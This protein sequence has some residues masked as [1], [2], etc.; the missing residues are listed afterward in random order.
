[1]K[2]FFLASASLGL[3]ASFPSLRAAE[4]S[5]LPPPWQHQD[6]G[7]VTVAGA[8]SVTKG[9][10]SLSGTLDIWGQNDGC[11][12]AWQPLKGNGTIIARVLSVEP[13]QNH[14]KGGVAVRESLAADARH[15]TLVDTPTD[16]AQF[17]VREQPG[18]VTTS[19]KSGL[20]KAV[21]P[22]WVKLV[23]EGDTFTGYESTDGRVW[24]QIGSTTLKLPETVHLGLVAS[25]HQKDKLCAATFD[26]VAVTRV[27]K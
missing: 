15:V 12:F 5:A 19:K 18:G 14:A 8:A 1:M 23:R 4:S 16:G 9:V 20:N 22:Y 11:H 13:T 27:A 7:A 3:A 21:M 17:L 2:L 10:F 26:H 24:V 6:I 25:S